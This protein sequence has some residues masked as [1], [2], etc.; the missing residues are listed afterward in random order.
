M[1][2]RLKK[3]HN[4][5]CEKGKRTEEKSKCSSEREKL[6]E[7]KNRAFEKTSQRKRS[8]KEEMSTEPKT[9][10]H[11]NDRI[12]ERATSPINI[13]SETV[14]S[15]IK[16]E[17]MDSSTVEDENSIEVIDL[18]ASIDHLV[19]EGLTS[20][21]IERGFDET[22][23]DNVDESLTF[24]KNVDESGFVSGGE[25]RSTVDKN[26]DYDHHLN[27]GHG[28]FTSNLDSLIVDV[29]STMY[30]TFEEEE[31]INQ[32]LSKLFLENPSL[33]NILQTQI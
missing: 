5:N 29:N 18:E 31:M 15:D 23:F 3:M 12:R 30:S 10:G 14:Q 16:T 9:I 28:E 26:F 22:L 17:P 33:I 13:K 7:S 2:Y 8:T 20:F 24:S 21:D 4:V 25:G 27:P 19:T 32:S 11:Q 1:K 6:L